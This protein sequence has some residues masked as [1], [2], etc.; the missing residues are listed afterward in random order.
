[1]PIVDS[2]DIRGYMV[3]DSNEIVCLDCIDNE[4]KEIVI[5]KDL[6]VAID[7]ES[8]K[9]EGCELLCDRCGKEL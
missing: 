3:P 8:R 7:T 2:E 6:I 1:M 9:K 4:E 5:E